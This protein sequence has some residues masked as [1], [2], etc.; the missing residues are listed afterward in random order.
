MTIQTRLR[1]LVLALFL[2]LYLLPLGV[3]PLMEPDETRYAEVPREMIASGDWITPHLNGLRYFEKPPLGYWLNGLAMLACGENE[4]AVRLPS[5]LSVGLSALLILLLVPKFCPREE[6]W[7]GPLAALIYLTSLEVAAVGTFSVLDSMLAAALTLTMVSFFLASEAQAGTKSRQ[8]WLVAAGLGCGLAFLIKGFLA[9]VVP[10]LAMG[11]FLAGQRRWRDMVGLA[12]LP[13]LVALVTVLPWGLAIHAREPD[14]WRYFF[15][16]EHVQRFMGGDKAQHRESF[17]A[18]VLSTPAMFIPWAFLLPAAGLGLRRAIPQ[19]GRPVLTHFCLAWF[20]LPFL[21][22]SLSSGKLLTYILPCFP[23]LACLASLGLLA[24]LRAKRT[25][26]FR[27]GSWAMALFFALGAVALLLVQGVGLEGVTPPY[28]RTWQWLLALAALLGLA[29][30]PLAAASAR[31]EGRKLI[32]FGLSPALFLGA[33]AF[34]MPDQLIEKKSPGELLLRHR[35]E[36]TAHTV[37]LSDDEPLRAVCWFLKR[38]DV[39]LVNGG[40]ELN[41]G[42]RHAEGQGRHLDL[43]QAR[44]RILANPGNIVLVARA[45][46]YRRWSAKLPAPTTIDDSG[47]DGY[48]LARY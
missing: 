41:Y 7:A 16:V 43:A 21:F 5:A 23:P 24:L 36:I 25:L 15:W 18:F 40:G 22:F 39:V 31:T 10:A 27:I 2:C 47:P 14:F 4:F 33:A 1:L 11:A 34:I 6:V 46:K 20:A 8:G 12:W 37:I 44:E 26:A 13:L 30:L 48:I 19:V 38:A 42:L 32:L 17:W 3:R 9:L 29:L 28:S 35:A 45:K